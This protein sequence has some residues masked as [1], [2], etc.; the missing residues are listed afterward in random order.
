MQKLIQGKQFKG[1]TL[2]L[3]GSGNARITLMVDMDET[4]I[5]SE[6]FRPGVRYDEV[7]Q[8]R[9]PMGGQEKIGVFVRPYCVEFLQ[10]MAQKFEIV[11]FTAAREDYASQVIDRLDPQR[12][13]VSARLYRQHCSNADGSLVKDFRVIANRKKEQ[14]ILVDNLIYSFAA[15]LDQGVYIKSYVHGREDYELEYLSNVLEKLES[16][17][18]VPKFLE[19]NL[20]QKEFFKMLG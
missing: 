13:L 12:N 9:N 2:N 15:D 3:P 6:E 7:V 17:A 19:E 11:V 10:R 1:N 16:G 18:S 5:H 8:I 20:R 14:M 4:L